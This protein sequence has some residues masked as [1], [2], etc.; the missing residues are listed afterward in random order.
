MA[1]YFIT[2]MEDPMPSAIE[3]AQAKRVKLFNANGQTAKI[4]ETVY[5]NAHAYAQR[6]L[7]TES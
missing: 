7:G 3:I 5:N 2:S 4:V 1:N 6:N